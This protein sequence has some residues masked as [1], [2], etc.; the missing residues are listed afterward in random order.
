MRKSVHSTQKKC[1]CRQVF[2]RM[3]DTLGADLGSPECEAMRAHVSQCPD[4]EAYLAS[5]QKTVALYTAYPAPKLPARAQAELL[6]S[7]KSK[8]RGRS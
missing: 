3:C 1:T 6:R 8:K 4:C 2:R 7:L 5:L